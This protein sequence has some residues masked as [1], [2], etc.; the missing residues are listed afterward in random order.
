MSPDEANEFLD[1]LIGQASD[2]SVFAPVDRGRI[3]TASE[4]TALVIEWI[5]GQIDLAMDP[6]TVLDELAHGGGDAAQRVFDRSYRLAQLGDDGRAT[7]LALSLFVPDA[8]RSGLTKVSGFD[9]NVK[10]LDEAVKRLAR[11]HL[12]KPAGARLIVAGLTRELAQARLSRDDRT[13]D[14]RKRFVAY[15]LGYAQAHAQATAEDYDALETEKDNLLN[16][17]DVAFEMK[18]WN[19]VTGLAYVI[20]KPVSGILRVRGYWHEALKR[21]EQA[22]KAAH[23]TSIEIDISNFAHNQAVIHKNLG[24]LDEAR[25]LYQ[26]SLE[27][28]QKL[29]DQSGIAISLHQ[30]AMLAQDQGELDEARRLYQQSLE[31]ERKLGNESRIANTVHQFAMLAQNQGELDEARLLYQQSLEIERKLGNQ[32]GIAISLHQLAMLAQQQGELDEARRLYQQSLEINQKVGNQSGI[33]DTLHQ[34]A[35]LAQDQD[36]LDEARR[37]YQQSLE[38]AK[39]LGNQSGIAI[40]LGQLGVLSEDEG[41]NDA[42]AEFFREAL[43]IFERLRSPYANLARQCLERVEGKSS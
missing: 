32:S 18:D 27:L 3:M 23:K 17:M 4:R 13:D 37:L 14:F 30:L 21:N 1:R 25:R 43:A 29:G 28:K 22:F 19:V 2:P 42:A 38:I 16:A 5:V 36:K 33:G 20:A 39:K 9:N 40:T 26:Q 15:F 24:Q 31:I 35:K 11:L 41:N 8:S 10:R 34:L 6:D 7:L 12:L